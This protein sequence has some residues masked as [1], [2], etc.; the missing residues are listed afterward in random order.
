MESSAWDLEN[1]K[2]LAQEPVDI[3][4]SSRILLNDNPHCPFLYR[5]G[6]V[7]SGCGVGLAWYLFGEEVGRLLEGM[8]YLQFFT[9][10]KPEG[11]KL[12]F[13]FLMMWLLKLA[14]MWWNNWVMLNVP[15][16]MSVLDLPGGTWCTYSGKAVAKGVFLPLHYKLLRCFPPSI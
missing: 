5:G 1:T 12:I 15:V 14:M 7:G 2:S 10:Y 4:T 16:L 3:R 11:V 13:C 6:L 9:V 8:N